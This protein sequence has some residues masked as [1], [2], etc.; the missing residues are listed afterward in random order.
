MLF[1][2]ALRISGLRWREKCRPILPGCCRLDL[3]ELSGVDV[4]DYYFCS[5]CGHTVDFAYARLNHLPVI[6]K[7]TMSPTF[8]AD[9]P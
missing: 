1:P 3:L 5:R 8:G 6:G 9:R 4:I 2:N 7:V